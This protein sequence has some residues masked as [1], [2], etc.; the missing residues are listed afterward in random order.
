M[1]LPDREQKGY[2]FT[3]GFAAEMNFATEAALTI[4]KRFILSLA[5]ARSSSM[6]MGSNH[7][8][9]NKV[10]PSAQLTSRIGL[11]LQLLQDLLPESSFSPR[12]KSTR[13]CCPRPVS[14]R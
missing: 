12:I 10:K 11:L 7:T 4:A 1:A 2:W 5:T 9:I 8:A 14:I 3:S 6:L 13:H